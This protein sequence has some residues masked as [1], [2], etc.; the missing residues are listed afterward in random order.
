M[1]RPRTTA[2]KRDVQQHKREKAQAKQERRAA[3]R[4]EKTE[5]DS[6]RIDISEAELIDQLA[7][8]HAAVE[9]TT[10]SLEEFEQRREV[11]RRQLEQLEER[12]S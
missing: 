10:I 9:A 2:G 7:A 6:N 12:S 3:R 5:P 11:I 4:L 8:L 1:T